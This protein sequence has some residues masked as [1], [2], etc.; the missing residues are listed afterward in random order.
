MSEKEEKYMSKELCVACMK[1]LEDKIDAMKWTITALVSVST[2]I[3]LVA[4]LK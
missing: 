1:R 3:L 4:S 2:L